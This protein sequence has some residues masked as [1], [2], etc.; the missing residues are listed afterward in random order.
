MALSACSG[1]GDRKVRVPAECSQS[2][3]GDTQLDPASGPF[4]FDC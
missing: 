1:G 3:I 4:F 2:A